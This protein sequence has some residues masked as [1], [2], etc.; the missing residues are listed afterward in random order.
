MSPP[1]GHGNTMG[2]GTRTTSNEYSQKDINLCKL[3]SIY[4]EECKKKLCDSPTQY[5]SDRVYVT[6]FRQLLLR[7]YI[8]I[9][10][11]K[12][13]TKH[14][15]PCLLCSGLLRV[16]EVVDKEGFIQLSEAFKLAFPSQ[17]YRTNSAR[18]RFL[19]MPL[20]CIRFGELKA[21][22]SSWYLVAFL[23]GVDYDKFACFTDALLANKTATTSKISKSEIRALVGL[24][25]SDHGRELIKCSV[26]KASG[27]T[28]TA[29]RRHFGFDSMNERNKRLHSVIEETQKIRESIDILAATEDKAML[30]AMGI[31]ISDS[32]SDPDTDAESDENFDCSCSESNMPQPI[33]DTPTYESLE[34][35]LEC[36]C[37]NW[38]EV[39]Q[40]VE[41]QTECDYELQHIQEYL[42]GFYCHLLATLDNLVHISL[43]KQSFNAFSAT[44]KPSPDAAR[45]AAILNG[46]IVSDS[47]PDDAEDY[48]GLTTVATPQAK[49]LIE[50]KRKSLVRRVHRAKVKAIA[51]ANFLSKKVTKKVKTIV[52]R[53]PD[54]GK[55]IES[56]V[57]DCSVGADAWRRTGVITFDGNR[58]VKKK[59]TFERIRRHLEETYHHKFSHGT[60]VQLCVARNKRHRSATNYR[61]VA[62]VTCRRA[63]KGF[64][65][66]YNP[67]SHW[68]SALYKGLNFIQLT[69][70]SN[71]ININRDDASGYRLDTL[72]TNKQHQTPAVQGHATLTTH[73][74]YVNKYPS[75]IQTTSYNFT[76]TTIT[77]EL[78]AG[79]VKAQAI[80]CKNPAQ[81]YADLKMLSTVPELQPAFL[82]PHT[83]QPKSIECIRVD[84]AGDEGPSHDEVMFWWTARHI[85]SGNH[86][87]L[88]S[89]R[90]SGSS[91][92]NRVELQ[93]GCLAQGH[94]NLFIPSTLN[95]PC[96]NEETGKIDKDKLQ[97]NMESAMDVYIS[98][99]SG[100][101]CG[102][103]VINLF[104]GADSSEYQSM[105][106]T[107]FSK[108]I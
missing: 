86:V 48:V 90:S 77:G 33:I 78:C 19:Q 98:R 100:C 89:S 3:I 105:R 41:E 21:G 26:F 13:K 20:A 51:S 31:E 4:D 60:V 102:D 97:A 46:E 82:N 106:S 79:V 80:Y 64:K 2:R 92:L 68:S 59:A 47:E 74:D 103:T 84:G 76:A 53:F 66:R 35:V 54:I 10:S 38:F 87:T 55:S 67:D 71:I 69:D 58:R 56:F 32:E 65:L 16:A 34:Q 99:V 61:G 63:R 62:K 44:E 11:L 95:G 81:H 8:Y 57:Q 75:N 45:T 93:N 14:K 9:R 91:Y 49:K 15:Q 73:T 96:F 12:C 72:F 17:A 37:Y 28:P 52:D 94:S 107:N 43:L 5:Q 7:E 70:G 50:M 36:A 101:P 22:N 25:Q 83:S 29:A 6:L 18:E 85:E 108:G 24:A 88:L 42:D 1:C 23:K 104:K 40:Y 27:L 39:V 30:S